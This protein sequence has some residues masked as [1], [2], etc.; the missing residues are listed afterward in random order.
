MIINF[1][2]LSLAAAAISYTVTKSTLFEGFRWWIQDGYQ[3]EDFFVKL[4]TCPYCL[5]HWISLLLVLLS[6]SQFIDVG[7]AWYDDVFDYAV[8]T[9]SVVAASTFVG[10]VIHR[11]YNPPVTY[12][13]ELKDTDE[14]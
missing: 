10:A 7:T 1:V 3:K 12:Y 5:G 8:S 4:S 2:V 9:F 6:S 14:T 13:K 11:A